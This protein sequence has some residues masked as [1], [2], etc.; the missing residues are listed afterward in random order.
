MARRIWHVLLLDCCGTRQYARRCM[1]AT[2]A[3]THCCVTTVITACAARTRHAAVAQAQA[4]E[5]RRHA[6]PAGQLCGGVNVYHSQRTCFTVTTV[7]TEP[8]LNPSVHAREH[9]AGRCS[10]P[11]P[12][13]L[14]QNKTVASRELFHGGHCCT[15]LQSIHSANTIRFMQSIR[16]VT[17]LSCSMAATT[18]SGGSSSLPTSSTNVAAHSERWDGEGEKRAGV[19]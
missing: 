12:T 6:V 5:Q 8:R 7:K 1:H 14:L 13:V 9:A 15:T 2:S 18:S 3:A 17:H 10:Q 16:D 19:N 11:C 4:V